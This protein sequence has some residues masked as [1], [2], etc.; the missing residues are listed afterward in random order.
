LAQAILAQA[1]LAQAILAHL[2]S[3]SFKVCSG[4]SWFKVVRWFA[5]RRGRRRGQA[6]SIG[7]VG[8]RR[9]WVLVLCVLQ[10]SGVCPHCHPPGG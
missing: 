6:D 2:G 4:S 7:V 9:G 3:D 8:L 1:I 10:R 5:L